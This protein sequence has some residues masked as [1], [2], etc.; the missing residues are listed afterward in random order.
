[1]N[2]S[3][4]YELG[5]KINP[6]VMAAQWNSV[7]V[8]G[9]WRLVDVFWA[10]T[11]IVGRCSKDWALFGVD[12]VSP[13][14]ET[15]GE[16]EEDG[17]TK[18]QV[19][20]FF[21]LTDPDM[22]ITTHLPEDPRWQ[23]LDRPLTITEFEDYVYIRD[24][25]FQMDVT[26][27]ECSHQNCVIEAPQ[28]EVDIFFK[29]PESF[30]PDQQFRYLLYRQKTMD[31]I[32]SYPLERY[33]FYQ[34]TGDS[35]QYLIQ[36]PLTGRFKM[37]IFGQDVTQHNSFDLLCS[38]LIDCS[39]AKDSCI[40]L[41]D[42][43]DIGWGPGTDAERM[44][45]FATSH[46]EGI[47]ITED[48]QVE[49]HFDKKNSVNVLQAMKHNQLD[50]WLLKRHATVRVTEDEVVINLRLPEAGDYAFCLFADED[51]HEG[52]LANVCNYLIRN[53]NEKVG[54][55]KFPKLHNGV[56]GKDYLADQLCVQAISHPGGD[57][58]PE[59]NRFLVRFAHDDD[60]ELLVQLH[61]DDY[62]VQALTDAVTRHELEGETE[63]E[64]ELPGPGEFGL[65]VYAKNMNTQKSRI[66][67]V[68]TYLVD[69]TKIQAELPPCE[70]RATQGVEYISTT[71]DF[72]RIKKYGVF[73]NPLVGELFRKNAQDPPDDEQLKTF[74]KTDTK[75]IFDLKMPAFGE[76]YMNL[77]EKMSHGAL[78]DVKGYHILHHEGIP[79]EPETE[80]DSDEEVSYTDNHGTPLG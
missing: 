2:K 23:L 6:D 1:M 18:H 64:L 35:L 25:F 7:L 59:E 66:Y 3:A 57:I 75:A 27:T 19:N 63:F 21:F 40:P 38:Y 32:T 52:E 42:N 41:P 15:E 43:P 16:D 74:K 44:G 65:N 58:Q 34:K 54:V 60:T 70:K 78:V 4:A 33:V 30:S 68:H 11:C 9:E 36:L 13:D 14:S 12:D 62:E 46:K 10:S 80:D 22:L 73:Y 20:E 71:R 24:R 37:D 8:E 26:M 76:Y 61:S 56:L 47:I 72:Y 69:G 45:L 17:E 67:H 53:Q 50:E 55:S 39:K 79:G 29:L 48:G 5:T 51:G 31:N 28:G 77:Y 49:I